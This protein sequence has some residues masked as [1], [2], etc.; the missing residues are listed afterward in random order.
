MGL[1]YIVKT[2]EAKTS[3]KDIGISSVDSN[4]SLLVKQG[5]FSATVGRSF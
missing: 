5:I 2:K 3:L 1:Y 4:A